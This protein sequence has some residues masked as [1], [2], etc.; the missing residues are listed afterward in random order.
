MAHIP[1]NAVLA[2]KV[3]SPRAVGLKIWEI[4]VI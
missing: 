4:E 3:A 1:A 2:Y